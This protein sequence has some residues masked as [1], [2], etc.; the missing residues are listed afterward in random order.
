MFVNAI[1]SISQVI[2]LLPTSNLIF[3]DGF[4]SK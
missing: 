4:E 2:E 1:P 3:A